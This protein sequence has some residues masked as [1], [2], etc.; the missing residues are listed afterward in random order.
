MSEY[1]GIDI[2]EGTERV[3]DFSCFYRKIKGMTYF[4]CLENNWMWVSCGLEGYEG[5]RPVD[6]SNIDC[7]VKELKEENDKLW[8]KINKYNQL[9]AILTNLEVYGEDGQ[10]Q[11]VYMPNDMI[12]QFD[13][14]R[15]ENESQSLNDIKSDSIRSILNK[16]E[17]F[18]YYE[19]DDGDKHGSFISA[20][21]ID[22]YADEV[23]RGEV[24]IPQ[25]HQRV[26]DEKLSLDKKAKSLIDFIGLSPIFG[27]IDPEEQ[28]LLRKQCETMWEY[29]EILGK[30]IANF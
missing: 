28:E 24:F 29:S 9:S 1:K 2:P 20:E 16:E 4:S 3:R 27:A 14:L 10:S 8:A 22:N 13:N 19:T 6:Q 5:A 12:S 21:D 11:G 18:E 7:E 25:N 17:L 15:Y 23:G 26:I 30:R